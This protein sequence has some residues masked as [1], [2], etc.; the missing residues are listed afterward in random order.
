MCVCTCVFAYYLCDP[1][2]PGIYTGPGIYS[3]GGGGGVY[4]KQYSIHFKHVIRLFQ[5]TAF[6]TQRHTYVAKVIDINVRCIRESV[7]SL[8]RDGAGPPIV[9]VHW[10]SV[11]TR[12]RSCSKPFC[13]P[14][15][16]I[17]TFLY[18][19]IPSR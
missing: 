12:E 17:P 11:L 15:Y 1:Q 10:K 7:D 3:R 4:S 18:P 9:C 13:T 19:M 5:F 6:C 16:P 2:R 8:C 14:S